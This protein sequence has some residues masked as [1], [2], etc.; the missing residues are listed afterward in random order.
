MNGSINRRCFLQAT[1]ST[2]AAAATLTTMPNPL[3]AAPNP[4]G[5]RIYTSIK[6]QMFREKISLKEKFSLMKEMGYDGVELNSPGGVNKDEALAV[7]KEVG[8][9]IH[10]AVCSTH[11][12]IRLSD[13]NPDKRA[14]AVANLKTAVKDTHKVGGSAVLLVPGKVGKNETQ[15]QVWDLSTKGIREV[16]PL[17]SRLG[18]HILIENVWNGFCYTHN[19]PDNQSAD[20]PTFIDAIEELVRHGF[21][22]VLSMKKDGKKVRQSEYWDMLLFSKP[23]QE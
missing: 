20:L 7:S 13:P 5:K 23:N 22:K 2:L 16:L 4:K 21:R 10:G 6:M 9:P 11:W 12:K 14:K 15:Q 8:L 17:S 1:T 19:G 18:I 3:N